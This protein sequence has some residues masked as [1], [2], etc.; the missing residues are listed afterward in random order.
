[1]SQYRIDTNTRWWNGALK[2]A[3]TTTS[4][5]HIPCERAALLASAISCC[6]CAARASSERRGCARFFFHHANQYWAGF[7][8]H[9]HVTSSGSRR[10]P[11][12]SRRTCGRAAARP[13]PRSARSCAGSAPPGRAS[14]SAATTRRTEPTARSVPP[15]RYS[16]TRERRYLDRERNGEKR[17]VTRD[18]VL[19]SL[20]REGEGRS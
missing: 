11:R 8:N 3:L 18:C 20:P 13:R 19:K 16:E 5:A 9:K 15:P 6:L 1:M 14:A 2:H 10:K 12:R 17:R 4:N 7:L